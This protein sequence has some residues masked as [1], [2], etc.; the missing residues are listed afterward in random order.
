MQALNTFAKSSVISSVIGMMV[1]LTGGAFCEAILLNDGTTV[2]GTLKGASG[3]VI[4]VNTSDGEIILT[5]DQITTITFTDVLFDS[6]RNVY[7]KKKSDK[8]HYSI[9]IQYAGNMDNKFD[10]GVGFSL[11][12]QHI[13]D[14]G[15]G[16]QT[17]LG[18]YSAETGAIKSGET[19]IEVGYLFP[20]ILKYRLSNSASVEPFVGIGLSYGNYESSNYIGFMNYEEDSGSGL[21]PLLNASIVLGANSPFHLVLDLKYFINSHTSKG[22]ALF[23]GISMAISW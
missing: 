8:K 11:Y 1:F 17:N 22:N 16:I 15:L 18:F 19:D 10:A 9:G 7:G 21:S 2:Y 4:S 23:R 12:I 13:W 6:P 20:I 5:S 14:S 3:G